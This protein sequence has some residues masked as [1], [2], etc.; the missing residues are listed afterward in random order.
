M[1]KMT[2]YHPRSSNE[3]IKSF[4]DEK[5][6]LAVTFTG[7]PSNL[8]KAY[9]EHEWEFPPDHFVCLEQQKWAQPHL[10]VLA[11]KPL[12]SRL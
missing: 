12:R 7:D 2:D 4:A 10:H 5:P 9:E 6:F 3:D 8:I 11:L 1:P